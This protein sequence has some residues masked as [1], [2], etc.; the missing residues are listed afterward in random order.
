MKATDFVKTFLNCSD[1][2]LLIGYVLH[3]EDATINFA[4]EGVSCN[5]GIK[6]QE[7]Q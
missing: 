2:N 4:Q 3:C 6:I 5:L 1:I 7:M